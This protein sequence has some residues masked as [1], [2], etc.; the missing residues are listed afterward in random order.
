MDKAAAG[1]WPGQP[2]VETP[3]RF[4]PGPQNAQ[5][6]GLLLPGFVEELLAANKMATATKLRGKFQTPGPTGVLEGSQLILPTQLTS[7]CCSAQCETA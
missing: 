5:E 1:Q 6:V 4:A 3:T 2:T 7:V